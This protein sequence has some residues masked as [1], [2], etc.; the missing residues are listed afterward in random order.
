[1][2]A[3]ALQPICSAAQATE[4]LATGMSD[5]ACELLGTPPSSRLGPEWRFR[6]RGSLAV[7]VDGAK[8]GAWYDHEAGV[9]GGPIGLVAHCRNCSISEAFH[10]AVAWLGVSTTAS[11]SWRAQR[12]RAPIRPLGRTSSGTGWSWS[13]V[14]RRAEPAA[15]S[16]VEVYLASR[17]LRLPEDA[18]LRFHRQCLRG[19]ERVPAMIALMTN[20]IDGQPCGVH[21]TFLTPD[22]ARKAPGPNG[23]A[24]MML[25][26]AGV[27]RLVPDADVTHSLGLAEGIETALSVMQFFGWRPA[28]AATS[29]GAIRAFPVLAGI[30]VLTLFADGDGPGLKAAS[31]CATRWRAAGC[32]SRICAPTRGDFNDLARGIA[33]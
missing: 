22:G 13:S 33:P 32:E 26:T 20:P 25:G 11:P 29:A 31:M 21:R 19:P 2:T 18:P 3:P 4:L 10:W 23:N 5:L 14:W 6:S 15:G 16:P 7:V 9:G 28:W 24:R 30:D 27:I 17:S 12:S 1:M 8:R